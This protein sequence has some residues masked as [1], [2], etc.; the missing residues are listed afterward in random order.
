MLGWGSR[1]TIGALQAW[2]EGHQVDVCGFVV[3]DGRAYVARFA[4]FVLGPVRD[5]NC[6]GSGDVRLMVASIDGKPSVIGMKAKT[7]GE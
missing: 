5:A 6:P 3:R 2:G 1:A 7:T 4:G